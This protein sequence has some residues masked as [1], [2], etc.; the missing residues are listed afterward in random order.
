[1][2]NKVQIIGRLGNDPET[3]YAQS[4]SAVTSI[5]VATSEKW[6]DKDG[7]QQERT[8]WHRVTFFGKL[9]EIA[10]EYLKKGSLVYVEGPLR[11]EK[12]TDKEGV[13]KY[14]TTIIGNEMKMLSSRGDSEGAGASGEQGG[15]AGRRPPSS[16]GRSRPPVAGPGAARSSGRAAPVQISN[17]PYLDDDIPF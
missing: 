17:D 7:Q 2:L 15:A 10:A 8:E 11:T 16:G 12:Y 3:R 13:E 1:M 5:S 4:G 14:S 6:K 9:A